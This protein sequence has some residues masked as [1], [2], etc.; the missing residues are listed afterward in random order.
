[1]SAVRHVEDLEQSDGWRVNRKK[2][3]AVVSNSCLKELA[4]E[5]AKVRGTAP[6]G[7]GL[8]FG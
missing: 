6:F 4:V 3:G 7:M 8:G 5:A 1:M 2:S